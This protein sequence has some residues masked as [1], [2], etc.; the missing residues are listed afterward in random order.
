MCENNSEYYMRMCLDLALKGQGIVS[1]NPL[2]GCVVVKDSKIVSTGFHGENGIFHA[3]RVA[4][5]KDGDFSDATLYVN[6]Q[7]CCHTGKTPP[8]TDI[9]IEKKIGKVIY[10]IEDPD[11]NSVKFSDNIL[12]KNGIAVQKNVLK[13]DCILINRAFFINNIRKRPYVFAKWGQTID[14][15]IADSQSR[16]KFITGEKSRRHSHF[17]RYCADGI[18]VGINTVLHDNPMLDIRY[19]KNKNLKRI[20]LDPNLRIN[21]EL[22]IIKTAGDIQ[23]IL[24]CKDVYSEKELFLKN[25]GVII[26]NISNYSPDNILNILYTEFCINILMV[27]G[28][29]KT[30]G[31]FFE[32]DLVDE[33]FVYI[34]PLISGDVKGV[35]CPNIK[36]EID[37]DDFI[38]FRLNSHNIIDN[39]ILLN[40][41]GASVNCLLG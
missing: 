26:K 17:L 34:A 4:L 39:D 1:P 8:C 3:E 12:K 40:Y 30:I 25:S 13:K 36:D 27:E 5:M 31:S 38:R 28:G 35:C 18:L 21:E 41:T 24:F 6:L 2:V 37:I 33:L 7:P 14:G 10:G 22:D 20:I 23:T 32:K 11:K 29:G 9:I 15:K 19:Y 16:S